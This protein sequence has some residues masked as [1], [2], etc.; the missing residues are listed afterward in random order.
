MDDTTPGQMVLGYMKK[1]AKQ[2]Y[3]PCVRF[4]LHDPVLSYCIDILQLLPGTW[5]LYDE[6]NSF[7]PP[8]GLGQCSSKQQKR[9]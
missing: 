7:L 9:K 2:A 5:E 1:K 6:I 4:C 8:V 3:D